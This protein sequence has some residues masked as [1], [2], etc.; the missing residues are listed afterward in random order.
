LTT[1]KIFA[2][3]KLPAKKGLAVNRFPQSL[4]GNPESSS[5]VGLG[6]GYPP[7]FLQESRDTATPLAGILV[8]F[9]LLFC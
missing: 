7:V 3:L 6:A 8:D 4:N 1:P 9:S 2:T 5:P